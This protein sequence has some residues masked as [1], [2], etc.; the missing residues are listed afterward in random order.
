MITK[1]LTFQVEKYIRQKDRIVSPEGK[2]V[3]E[4]VKEVQLSKIR[5]NRLNPRLELNVDKLNELAES[6]K[7][8]GLLEPLIVRPF[9]DGYEVVVGER[10]YRASQQANLKTVPV[11]IRD[12]TDDQVIEL[13]LIENIQREDLSVVEKARSCKQ[14]RDKFPEKYPTWQKVAEKIGVSF[15]TV[16]IWVRTL[17]LPEEVQKLVAPRETHRVPEGKIDYQTALHVVER[18]KEPEKQVEMIKEIAERRIPQREAQRI[19]R[20]VV[21]EPQKPIKEVIEEIAE[22]PYELPF[23]L[24]HLD[25]ILKGL[26]T[27]TSRKGIPDPKIKVGSIVHAAVWEPHFADLRVTNIERKRLKY[28]DEDD[29]KREGG[30]TLEEF[31]KVWKKIHGEWNEDEF[32]YVIHFEKVK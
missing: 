21:K 5:P 26:K 6:I 4:I 20:E 22:E 7:E 25:P 28:F 13:N 9:E 27:Q 3:S 30:Y 1:T 17:R 31:K 23:R 10:R 16:K 32:V 12:Y 2:K 19:I 14:L 29:A 15:E 24:S 18:I 11:I 8:V